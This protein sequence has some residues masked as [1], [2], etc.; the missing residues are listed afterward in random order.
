MP[1]LRFR[2]LYLETK[3]TAC[4]TRSMRS[5]RVER[6]PETAHFHATSR[7]LVFGFLTVQSDLV[8]NV[9]PTAPA[10]QRD[11]HLA[12]GVSIDRE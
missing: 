5:L 4:D 1:R 8:V 3:D 6:S 7:S 2:A 10:G 12:D 9:E 11:V